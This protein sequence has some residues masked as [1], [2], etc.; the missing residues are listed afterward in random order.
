MD[1]FS[2]THHVPGAFP[3]TRIALPQKRERTTALPQIFVNPSSSLRPLD[4]PARSHMQDIEPPSS[5]GLVQFGE[6]NDDIP[7]PIY[8]IASRHGDCPTTQTM[9]FSLKATPYFDGKLGTTRADVGAVSDDCVDQPAV[10]APSVQDHHDPRGNTSQDCASCSSLKTQNTMLKQLVKEL[11]A[12]RDEALSSVESLQGWLFQA[13]RDAVLDVHGQDLEMAAKIPTTHQFTDFQC[14]A[15]PNKKIR[16]LEAKVADLTEQ[17]H[18]V[19]RYYNMLVDEVKAS[20]GIASTAPSA[21]NAI[22]PTISPP[23]DLSDTAATLFA[24]S[25]RNLWR[26][27][28]EAGSVRND[29]L[30]RLISPPHSDIDAR[31]GELQS[32]LYNEATFHGQAR[33]Q[34]EE[35]AKSARKMAAAEAEERPISEEKYKIMVS[36]IERL[37]YER[38]C[39]IVADLQ[40]TEEQIPEQ[41]KTFDQKL[42]ASSTIDSS[43]P[44]KDS[45]NRLC[46]SAGYLEGYLYDLRKLRLDFSM[47]ATDPTY[48]TIKARLKVLQENVSREAERLR[49]A[50][51]TLMTTETQSPVAI[52]L[53]DEKPIS[54]YAAILEHSH[55]YQTTMA[56]EEPENN[57][58]GLST[59]FSDTS[60]DGFD[61][62]VTYYT[63][64][65]S[66]DECG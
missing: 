21:R 55:Q 45:L 6:S 47:V 41:I 23:Y 4:A 37:K 65:A 7:L 17:L 24:L 14:D 9:D 22:T 29:V 43:M 28:T 26:C 25:E 39:S 30:K 15:A 3:E 20:S 48:E 56:V 44:P 63:P 33:V 40:S 62:L 59:A 2:T 53:E 1:D 38:L 35:M 31:I 50:W 12:E 11:Q 13:R 49:H 19:C 66:D 36:Q 18:N 16:T 58:I 27:A 5:Q 8:P 34:F 57:Q 51:V 52:E 60:S 32:A 42:N 54:N 64:Q 46:I 10:N 61:E